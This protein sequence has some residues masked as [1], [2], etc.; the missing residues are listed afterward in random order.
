MKKNKHDI[1]AIGGEKDFQCHPDDTRLISQISPS[2]TDIHIIGNMDHTL[3]EQ[4]GIP[5]IMSYAPSC[6]EPIIQEVNE[7][8]YHWLTYK[9]S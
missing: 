9:D 8:I 7:K 4:V 6:K 3:R 1:L 5:S 2:Q